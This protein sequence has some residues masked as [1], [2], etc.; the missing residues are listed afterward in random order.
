MLCHREEENFVSI[1]SKPLLKD[2]DYERSSLTLDKYGDN[3]DYNRVVKKLIANEVLPQFYFNAQKLMKIIPYGNRSLEL[4]LNEIQTLIEAKK[5]KL[6]NL[7]NEL[8][9]VSAALENH[10]DI[11]IMVIK[12]AAL[13]KVY[14]QH[15]FR[16]MEDID[17]LLKSSE[18]IWRII[19]IFQDQK[20]NLR[21]L[22]L[23]YYE[24]CV[25]EKGKNQSD[26]FGMAEFTYLDPKSSIIDLHIEAFPTCGGVI[27]SDLWSR[28]IP[29]VID[30]KTIQTLSPED[31]ILIICAHITRHSFATLRDLND[32][33]VL[34]KRYKN[35]FDWEYLINATRRNYFVPVLVPLLNKITKDFDDN[36]IPAEVYFFLQRSKSSSIISLILFSTGKKDPNFAGG[37][38]SF[39][40]RILQALYIFRS[41]RK[42][43]GLV[44]SIRNA[45]I[46]VYYLFKTGRPYR[47]WKHRLLK[48]LYADGRVVIVPIQPKIN[49][50]KWLVKNIALEKVESVAKE[51]R[52]RVRNTNN[53]FIIWNEQNPLELFL[54][55]YG[56]FTQSNYNGEIRTSTLTEIEEYAGRVLKELIYRGIAEDS[57]KI[58][59]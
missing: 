43:L 6:S 47:T 36:L 13:N 22:R 5:S 16:D 56:I 19:N 3:F 20:Y 4:Y 48:R 2:K 46:S 7:F 21:K 51:K 52:I 38:K 45:L 1:L 30:N 25:L 50:K 29:L 57:R 39:V 28:A 42:H 8:K 44:V 32:I 18:D 10:G 40:G 53:N 11:D 58:V 34:L 55:A 59:R 24:S 49:G 41:S 35:S 27:V 14:P 9:K 23:Q 15:C 12:G 54:S 26:F 37:S 31:S 33:Y 17:L